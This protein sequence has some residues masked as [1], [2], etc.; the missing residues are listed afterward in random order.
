MATAW[1][2]AEGPMAAWKKR[3]TPIKYDKRRNRI[4]VMSGRLKGWWCVATR[5]DRCPH[6]LLFS[7]RPGCNGHLLALDPDPKLGGD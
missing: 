6:G 5:Y 7:L 1:R 4:E 2:P 3:E